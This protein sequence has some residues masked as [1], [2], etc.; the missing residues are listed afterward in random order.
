MAKRKISK[1]K[2]TIFAVIIIVLIAAI[3]ATIFFLNSNKKEDNTIKVESVDKIEGYDYTLSSN[4]TK[5]YKSL[6]KE[7]KN[8]LEA[9]DVDEAKY[10]DLVT[11][12]FVADFY[13]LDNK[14]NKNDIGGVQFVYK[15]FRDD[16]KKLAANSIYKTVENNVYGDRKQD[17]PVVS[18]VSTEKK[19]SV[20]FKY[21]DK[22]DEAAY[23]IN[24]EV[25]Y[26]TDLGYQQSGSLTLIH[27]DKKIEVAALE[28]PSTN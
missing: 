16:F 4:A 18:N 27:N 3:V 15:D 13:N 21:G 28:E 12:L 6:F 20:S 2:I 22:T 23:K 9:D 5:Y 17:L 10:A 7:L 26:K 1:K 24:F 8:V 14:V 19:D 11:K 25:E